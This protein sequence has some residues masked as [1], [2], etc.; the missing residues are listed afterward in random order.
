MS[1]FHFSA[2]KNQRVFLTGHTGFKGSWMSVW[3]K[4]LGAKVSGYALEP[5]KISLYPNLEKTLEQESE[6]A[7]IRNPEKIKKAIL[8]FQPDI[9][10]HLAAQPLVLYSYKNPVE[11]FE[12]NTLGTTYLLDAVRS[13]EKKC[14]VVIITTD[15]VYENNEWVYPYREA[16][17][18]GGYDP[19]SASKA[20]AE[21]VVSAFRSSFFNSEKI[22]LHQ[23]GI[24]TARAG[25]VIGGG[26]FAEN[27]LV[28]DIIRA[29]EQNRDV[30]VRNPNSIRPWQHVLEPISGYL[31]LALALH[32]DPAKFGSAFNFGPH[33]EDFI[34]VAD[35][36]SKAITVWGKG[37]SR[38]ESLTNSPHEAGLLKLDIN[39]A[40][41]I[42]LWKPRWNSATGIEKSILWYKNF[43][44]K[45][46]NAYNL[47]VQDIMDYTNSNQ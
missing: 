13:L 12:V 14:T 26:D 44:R 32:E 2:Y 46:D 4:L 5:E 25:N 47:C 24:A 41:D 20:A 15:K 11:T 39:K 23:K 36:V 34:S 30:V 29:L 38:I 40:Q 9:I 19:Y 28:P 17:T 1:E 8:D 10:F 22:Q 43:F 16:D 31:K 33:N 35:L 3:L 7:D 45:K 18:L 21:I 37:N 6:Y 42:L 27:R